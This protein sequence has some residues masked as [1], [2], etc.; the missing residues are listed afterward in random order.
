[1]G[2][3]SVTCHPTEVDFPAYTPDEAGTPFHNQSRVQD[4]V[5]L[6]GGGYSKD[7]LPAKDDHLSQITE[8]CHDLQ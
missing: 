8:Q 5:N 6:A 4:L 2:S 3:H 1:M 7:S